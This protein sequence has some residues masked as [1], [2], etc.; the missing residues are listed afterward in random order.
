MRGGGK[1]DHYRR[2]GK[3]VEMHKEL[4]PVSQQSL[5]VFS[6]QLQRAV[7]EPGKKYI[8]QMSPEDHY[9]FTFYHLLEHFIRAE[10]E[11]GWCWIF[12]F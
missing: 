4:M 5:Q 11:S 9:L 3:V 10:S 12:I 2:N 7:P 8:C 1:H 6:G